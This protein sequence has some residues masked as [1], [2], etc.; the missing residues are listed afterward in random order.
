IYQKLFLN[1]STR[2]I[3]VTFTFSLWLVVSLGACIYI[4]RN[5]E[6]KIYEQWKIRNRAIETTLVGVFENLSKYGDLVNSRG[7][8]LEI[9]KTWGLLRFEICKDGQS[10]PPRPLVDGCGNDGTK[11]FARLNGVQYELGFAWQN[12]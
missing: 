1:K 11:Y 10:V 6:K 4:Y 5:E 12:S 7:T 3:V 8:V 9:G 2:F